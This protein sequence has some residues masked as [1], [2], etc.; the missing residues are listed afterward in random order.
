MAL[1][2]VFC[3][4]TG[5]HLLMERN[6]NKNGKNVKGRAKNIKRGE[7]ERESMEMK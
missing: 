2:G 1:R 4:P 6:A 5:T 7:N 3:I